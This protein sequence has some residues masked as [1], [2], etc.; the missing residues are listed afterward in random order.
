MP[1]GGAT[2]GASYWAVANPHPKAPP[3]IVVEI[4]RPGVVGDGPGNVLFTGLALQ[5]T[6]TAVTL[7]VAVPLPELTEQ[8]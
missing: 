2:V 5:E 7:A 3:E 8:V 4:W 6:E 1:G